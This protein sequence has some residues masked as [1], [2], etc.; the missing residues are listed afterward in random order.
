[1]TQEERDELAADWLRL[2][3]EDHLVRLYENGR[4]RGCDETLYDEALLAQCTRAFKKAIL[5]AAPIMGDNLVSDTF[6]FYRIRTLVEHGV[7]ETQGFAEEF[8]DTLVRLA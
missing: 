8:G 5:I 2:T 3:K 1:M 6:L 4:I 7:L